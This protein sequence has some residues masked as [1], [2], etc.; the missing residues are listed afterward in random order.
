MIEG[1]ES[2]IVTSKRFSEPQ[3]A[4]EYFEGQAE[5]LSKEFS[6]QKARF[7]STAF[8]NQGDLAYCSNCEE[9]LQVYHGLLWLDD[10]EL[11]K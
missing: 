9:D 8:W 3:Q 10:G 1:W 5:L 6:H 2:D 7:R 11:K 4:K